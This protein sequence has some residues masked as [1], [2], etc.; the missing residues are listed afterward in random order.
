MNDLYR[1]FVDQSVQLKGED[2]DRERLLL[3][4]IGTMSEAGEAM[5]VVKKHLF[6]DKPLDREALVLELGDEFWYLT[7]LM[8]TLGIF[9]E[10]VMAKNINKLIER[11]PEKYPQAERE[12]FLTYARAFGA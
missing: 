11:F 9:P 3:A 4:V 12:A 8:R 1:E 2:T 6:H 5:D 10:E 7:L